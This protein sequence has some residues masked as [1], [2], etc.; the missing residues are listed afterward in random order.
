MD[1]MFTV[2]L[3]ERE[4]DVLQMAV[5]QR[6][7]NPMSKAL[8]ETEALESAQSKIDRVIARGHGSEE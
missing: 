4:W 6:M 2:T 1:R 8:N 5:L 7:I 3:T